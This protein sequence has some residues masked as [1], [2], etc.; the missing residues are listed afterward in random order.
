MDGG[1]W[2]AIVHGAAKSQTQLSDF[3]FFLNDRKVFPDPLPQHLKITGLVRRFLR[4]RNM[5]S[6]NIHCCY[7]IISTEFKEKQTLEQDELFCCDH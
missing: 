1:A 2:W 3:T 4:R 6:S 5:S 7:I